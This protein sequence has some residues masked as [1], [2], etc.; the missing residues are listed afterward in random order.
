MDQLVAGEVLLK[1]LLGGRVGVWEGFV[2]GENGGIDISLTRP[3]LP[4]QKPVHVHA[5]LSYHTIR[6]HICNLY[7]IIQSAMLTKHKIIV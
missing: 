2:C 6:D 7:D 1:D 4:Q 3:A 5:T